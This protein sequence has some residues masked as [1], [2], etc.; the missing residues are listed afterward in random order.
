[1]RVRGRLLKGRAVSVKGKG[2]AVVEREYLHY[3]PKYMRY[4]KRRNRLHAHLP[5]CLNVIEGDA[6]TIAECRP[7]AKTVSFV[8][9]EKVGA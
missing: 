3:I 5:P 1:L 2:L 4:E 6:V 8:V 7:L 9:V